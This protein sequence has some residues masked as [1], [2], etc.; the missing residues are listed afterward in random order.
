MD[1]SIPKA[2]YK[3]TRYSVY[4]K[5]P[6]YIFEEGIGVNGFY[7]VAGTINVHKNG[8]RYEA[9]ITA[10]A[11]TEAGKYGRAVFSCEA[12]LYVNG[13][14]SDRKKLQGGVEKVE[15]INW[16]S[17]GGTSFVLPVWES[18]VEIGLEAGYLLY[19]NASMHGATNKAA[20]WI[21]DN[22][23]KKMGDF[24]GAI[25]QKILTS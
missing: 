5:I 11:R 23:W 2:K 4:N 20:G 14:E 13:A 10:K 7:E 9:G 6:Y 12:I 21:Y 17:L 18:D 1:N 25:R 24:F 16:S 15:D 8:E 3:E 19:T 22:V